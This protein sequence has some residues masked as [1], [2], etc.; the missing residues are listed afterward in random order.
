MNE[1]ITY[2]RLPSSNLGIGFDDLAPIIEQYFK[3]RVL[4]D[5]A[6]P[7]TEYT[8]RLIRNR[9][10]GNVDK[11]MSFEQ[12]VKD[13][14]D[15][16]VTWTGRGGRSYLRAIKIVRTE[17]TKAM[18]FGDLIG[19]YMSGVDV[20][21]VWVT[22]ED[23][24]VRGESG[25]ARFPHTQLDL[26]ESALMGAFYNG[27]KIKFPGDPDASLENIAMCRCSLYF[28][29]KGKTNEDRARTNQAAHR[30]R[31]S[32]IEKTFFPKI[33]WELKQ[34]VTQ[35]INVLDLRG[36]EYALGR[37][38]EIIKFPEMAKVLKSLYLKTAYIEANWMM[39]NI[40]GEKKFV[41][42]LWEFMGAF[43][44]G[45]LIGDVIDGV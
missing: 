5:S 33:L 39:R 13:F 12:A 18:S 8:K 31:R 34:Q 26:N 40:R 24:R 42:R 19:A 43:F 25:Y 9:L 16:A 35:F 7:I 38:D 11:G 4:N 17:T 14:K 37:I 1:S 20:D 41:R 27:E 6:I 23:E 32:K 3:I 36:Y 10:I 28:R 21:K 22:S 45:R 2:K 15:T 29:E 44:A 30:M